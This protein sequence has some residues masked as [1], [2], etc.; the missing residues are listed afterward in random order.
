MKTPFRKTDGGGEIWAFLGFKGN[1]GEIYFQT[2]KFCRKVALLYLG[3][4]LSGL[5][6]KA[7]IN[8]VRL[9]HVSLLPLQPMKLEGTPAEIFDIL[10]FLL[11]AA[12]YS[13][14]PLAE[15]LSHTTIFQDHSDTPLYFLTVCSF[16]ING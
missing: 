2:F 11:W 16:T 8:L 15:S 6:Q 7:N 14:I 10:T 4:L 3:L 12:S 5:P 9:K 13:T 1:S